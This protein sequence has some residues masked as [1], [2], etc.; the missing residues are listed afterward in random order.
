MTIQTLRPNSSAGGSATVTVVGTGSGYVV[1]LNDNLDTTYVKGNYHGAVV[2]PMFGDMT[3][4]TATQRI[5]SLQIRLRTARDA[6]STRTQTIVANMFIVG[7]TAPAV[8]RVQVSRGLT[9]IL[10]SSGPIAITAP[11]GH[12]WTEANVNAMAANV[13][14]YRDAANDGVFCRVYEM[15][16]DVDV[17]NQPVVTGAPVVTNFT[18]NAKPTVTWSYFDA[19][20]DPQVAYRVK[21]FDAATIAMGNFNPDTSKAAWDSGDVADDVTTVDSTTALQNGT[22][23]TA[24]VKVAQ[25]WQGPSGT[26]WWSAWGASAPFTVTFTTPYAPVVNA[27]TVLA[28][29]NQ[30]RAVIDVTTPI[31]ILSGDDSSFEVGIGSWIA[32]ANCTVARDT[33]QAASGAASLKMTS[34]AAGDMTTLDNLPMLVSPWVL[35]GAT[36]TALAS[37]RSAVSARAVAVGIRWIDS[38]GGTISTTYGTT[39]NDT[40][41]GFTQV[42]Y[43]AVAPANAWAGRVTTKVVATGAAAEVHWMDK[44]SLHAGSSTVWTSGGLAAL[45]PLTPPLIERGEWIVDDRGPVDN[46]LHPQVASAGSILQDP[47]YGFWWDPTVSDVKWHWLDHTIP[48]PGN[49]PPSMIMWRPM[50]A[51]VTAI[52]FGLSY[53]GGVTYMTP[54]VPS[55]THVFSFW[56]WCDATTFSTRARIDW[57]DAA[58]TLIS[59][60]NGANVTLTTTPQLVSVTGTA[61]AN[62]VLMSGGADNQGSNNTHRVYFTRFGF[63]LG[64]IPVNGKQAKGRPDG[65]VWTPVRYTEVSTGGGYPGWGEGQRVE[66]P[67]YEYTSG[68]PVLYRAS[69]AYL[70]ADGSTT[71]KSPDSNVVVAYATPPPVTLLR[72]VIDPTLQVAVNRRKQASFTRDDDSQI[73]HPLGADAAPIRIRDWVGGEDG[74]LVVITSTDA[75]FARLQG[76]LLTND[77]LQVQWAQ[78]GRTYLQVIS[79]QSEETLST[80][81]DFCDVDGTQ[82]WTKF[83]VH[84]LGYVE[85]VAP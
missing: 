38:T 54:V 33:A 63:G 46:W 80:D 44:I 2:K 11:G 71:L 6:A 14:W 18:N 50:T 79:R 3:P 13:V 75:Q 41:T 61:P 9:S 30:Y 65:P 19:D 70:S 73:F 77:V 72:S 29:N 84:T 24:Y 5:K 25:L 43:T 34:S 85:T 60:T 8:G 57:R 66:W 22:S 47:H 64:T 36:Y 23:Y 62:A 10:T 40:T 83:V 81:S 31:N 7:S 58:G 27:V 56:A 49:T 21:I 52:G 16:V 78:G 82:G 68:R 74:Q 55:G 12:S 32:L 67:D 15:Y 37:F 45:D 35:G 69:I 39:A 4:L 76:L 28:E 53:Y 20:N 26:R 51:A 17:N 1:A 42:S 59:S 48:S